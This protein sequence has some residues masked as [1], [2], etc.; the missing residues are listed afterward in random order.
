MCWEIY[1]VH[2]ESGH[3]HAM[4]VPAGYLAAAVACSGKKLQTNIDR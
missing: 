1:Y 4:H 3:M 2:S